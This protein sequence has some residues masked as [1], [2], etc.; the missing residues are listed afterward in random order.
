M[1]D[2]NRSEISRNKGYFT[3]FTPWSEQSVGTALKLVTM[4][5]FDVHAK[6][7]L[8]SAVVFSSTGDRNT[9]METG[10]N[11]SACS[12]SGS[13]TSSYPLVP[14]GALVIMWAGAQQV[15]NTF[16]KCQTRSAK[17]DVL[18]SC[19]IKSYELVH[20]QILVLVVM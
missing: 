2:G 12:S 7:T 18:Q 13:C 3:N 15:P 20:T 5:C 9:G 14:G 10:R 16:C 8:L 11:S 4:H 17:R 1:R 6:L 19:R